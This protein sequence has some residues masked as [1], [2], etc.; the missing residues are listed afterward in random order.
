L[1][2]TVL[3]GAE[4]PSRKEKSP[5][6]EVATD[7]DLQPPPVLVIIRLVEVDLPAHVLE[8]RALDLAA[9]Q[10]D[11]EIQCRNGRV[12][13]DLISGGEDDIVNR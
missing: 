8:D 6:T 9:F 11:A 3:P 12:H 10:V 5:L 7:L 2:G 13:P 1:T 4:N